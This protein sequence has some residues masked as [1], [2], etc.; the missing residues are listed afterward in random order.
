MK[1]KK[2]NSQFIE[3]EKE[4]IKYNWNEYVKLRNLVEDLVNENNM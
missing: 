2:K 4:F 1:N 3:F